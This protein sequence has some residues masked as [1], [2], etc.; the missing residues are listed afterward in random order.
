MIPSNPAVTQTQTT[1]I[2]GRIPYDWLSTTETVVCATGANPGD[3]HCAGHVAIADSDELRPRP[4][5]RG[6]HTGRCGAGPCADGIRAVMIEFSGY[7]RLAVQVLLRAFQDSSL[8]TVNEQP[9]SD[10]RPGRQMH[11]ITKAQDRYSSIAFLKS[12]GTMLRLWCAWLNISAEDLHE[13]WMASV[14]PQPKV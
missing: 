4:K 3:V 1:T 12:N 11:T 9:R 8:Y 10:L 6:R 13:R 7:R 2:R 5:R 14:P